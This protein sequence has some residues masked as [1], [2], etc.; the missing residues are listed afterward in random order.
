MLVL[1]LCL[2]VSCFVLL[3][4]LGRKDD[5]YS[6]LVEEYGWIKGRMDNLMMSGSTDSGQVSD[7][8]EPL[9][10]EG[11]E[12]TVRHAGYVP[13]TTNGC[14]HF[15]TSGKYYIID[16]TGLPLLFFSCYYNI[17][18]NEWDMDLFKKAAHL[19]SDDLIMVKAIIED[20]PDSTVLRFVVAAM[21]RNYPSFTDNIMSYLRIINDG[22]RY[23]IETYNRLVEEKKN[24]DLSIN[25]FAS[26]ARQDTKL[27]S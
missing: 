27:L 8:Y 16:T 7:A 13:E 26:S 19:M 18:T 17:Q 5:K 14:V 24:Q 6:E 1:I 23:L 12:A 3:I 9:T 22:D 10:L 20:S 4:I 11:V 2:S 21:D 15:V 25:P